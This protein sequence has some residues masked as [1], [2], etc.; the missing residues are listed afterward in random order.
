MAGI[1]KTG[2]LSA[3][4]SP[5]PAPERNRFQ[6]LLHGFRQQIESSPQLKS[7]LS[8]LPHGQ[9]FIESLAALADGPPTDAGVKNLQ[10]FLTQVPGV[11]LSTPSKRSGVDGI[12]GNKSERAMAHFFN[13]SFHPEGLEAIAQ[14]V[15]HR[16]ADQNRT[17]SRPETSFSPDDVRLP[18]IDRGTSAHLDGQE[19]RSALPITEETFFPQ[20]DSNISAARD[21]DCGPASVS[22]ILESQGYG[23]TNSGDVRE[24]LMEVNHHGATA[25]YELVRGLRAGSNNELDVNIIEGNQDFA[26]DPQAFL[27]QMRQ[28]LA[29]GKQVILLT[30]NLRIMEN[31][32]DASR[33][34][35]H[36]Q[37][38][39]SI[40]PNGDLVLADPGSR[41]EG[42]N[43][44]VSA[45]TFTA[46]YARRAAED[47]HNNMITIAR[48]ASID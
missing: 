1:S 36:Y 40:S 23:E 33:T 47:M 30:K 34:N 35:G 18:D 7:Q 4:A 41:G 20:Y 6:N 45:E 27:N 32:R 39:Q 8:E 14:R 25:S 15:A 46:A 3:P 10:R 31:G 28:E 11:D 26:N 2:P 17:V 21:S 13:Q 48:P 44:H 38:V 12:F 43:F 5:T 9:A 37:I 19:V 16:P 24:D 29:E 42:L 22:M